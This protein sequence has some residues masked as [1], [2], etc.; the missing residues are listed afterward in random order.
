M[1][2]E[3]QGAP[4]P[5]F[6]FLASHSPLL[7]QLAARAER[8]CFDDPNAAL[9]KLRQ[10]GELLAQ[11]VA[12]QT[13][14]YVDPQEG[15]RELLE[16]LSQRGVLTADVSRL[17]R[18]LRVVGN[19]A[20]HEHAGTQREALHQL[21]MAR[22]LAVW[23]H[24]A[25]KDPR[26]KAGPFLPPPDPSEASSELHDELDRLRQLVA[27]YEAEATAARWTA[28]QEAQ[29][30]EKAEAQAQAAYE[31]QRATLELAAE[32]EQRL[33]EQL[34]RYR[35]EELAAEQQAAASATTE[36][37][38]ARIGQAQEAAEQLVDLDEQATR[39]L[40]D[41][42]LR[43]AGWEADTEALSYAKGV[44]PQK[45]RNLA[46]AEWPTRSG[47]ADYVLFS[48]LTPLA[49]VEAKRRRKDVPAAIEQ[50]KRY[51]RGYSRE[52][53]QVSPGGPWGK[54]HV[55]FLFATNGRP[56]LRQIRTKSG[57]WFLDGRLPTN[58]PKALESWYTPG[59]LADL[60]KQ[61]IQAAEQRLRDE[62]P[63]YLP[64]REYQHDAVRAVERAIAGGRRELLVAMATGTGKTRTCIGIIYRLIKAGRFRRVLFLVDRTAL[65]EQAAN[66]FKDVKLE[67]Y[68]AFTDIYDVKELG[69]LRPDADT[70]LHIATIQGM[71]KRILFP[72][73]E[74][75]P[76]PVDAYDCVI[77]DECHRGYNLDREMSDAELTF[78]SEQD[79]ISKYTRVLDHFDAVKIG[80]TATPALHTTEIF[81]GPDRAPV[82]QYSYRQAVIDGWL[83]D[84]EP[85]VRIVTAL[86]E[87][88]MQWR[89]GEQMT[90]LDTRTQQLQLFNTPDEVN[91]EV[92]QFNR[93]VVTENF[94]RVVCDELA[95]H[96]DPSL[97]GKTLIFC[98]T[99]TH[100]DMVV[101]LLKES[102]EKQYGPIDDDVVKKI[103]GSSDKPLEL[104]R[105]FRNEAYPKVVVTVDL[106]TTGVDI[107]DIVNL[108]FIRRVRSRILY[109]QMLGRAT[110]LCPDLYGQTQDKDRFQIFDA[111]DLYA[112]L[113]D[114]T[115]MKPVV[116]QP[117]ITFAQLVDELRTVT[118]AT[119]RG[120]IH[121]QII[122]KLQTR[123]R[124]L[125]D[126]RL[127]EFQRLVG[128]RPRD[129]V[130]QLRRSTPQESAVW[131]TANPS[132]VELLD[133]IG[134][135]GGRLIV[136]EHEDELRRVERGYG[137]AQRP[138]DYLES[139]RNF[140]QDNMDRITALRIV[141]QRP[142]DLTREQLREL[143][144][145]LD[146]QGYT[147][148]NLQV[149]VRETTNQDIAATII[150]YIRNVV[151]DAPLIPYAERVR[152]AMQRILGSR[153]WTDA[154]RRWLDRIGK[155][156]ERET[157]VDRG[158]FEQGQFRE[159]G[160]FVRLNKVFD[161]KLE[162]LLG[163]ISD[164][165]WRAAA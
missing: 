56:Y 100:A 69:D 161:G 12:A 15:Q 40:I 63:D 139:F 131:F 79:Y 27:D 9:V 134:S 108:V 47:P 19:R 53:D 138:E 34:D 106:L 49:V 25:F 92:D 23:Y 30:R 61:D 43:E 42:Q 107:P 31:D 36:E 123:R 158:A 149:A 120:E 2:T 77:V 157:I 41:E 33:V 73:D 130:Q 85:P 111:V 81:G 115:Q 164:E 152:R 14:T 83:V 124:S 162:Q 16:R 117:D 148:A 143:K 84:H 126:E 103:T 76:V 11:Q 80:L 3:G 147:E 140:V 142:R 60:L 74:Y 86:A 5:N 90:L 58:H 52:A 96:I 45:G 128:M 163:E 20:A 102:F 133:R 146:R 29:L 122:A 153:Q 144:L 145:E 4:S 104:I 71:V 114:Y 165:I 91:I 26:Y 105:R 150:G 35:A 1:A 127:R 44:R 94:N 46:I 135:G 93:R 98:A 55:P 156:L 95:R 7:V 70:R 88:G 57:I 8:Y 110:R 50:A 32:T 129:L 97:P 160:G 136:S 89:R 118:D 141:C 24:R 28:E 78:R 137:D 132:I 39:R 72:T 121:D 67:N 64:L 17:F 54:Y 62:P 6:Q 48:G 119:A 113:E 13:G 116:T 75:H 101:G 59:G 37:I 68:Q 21:R 109:E 66:A 154:Q 125:N 18:D 155:Q 99:D 87:D 151:L 112:A 38:T 51:S 10:F 159:H 82:F 65:G 22:S